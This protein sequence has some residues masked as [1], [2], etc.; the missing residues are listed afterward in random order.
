MNS[1]RL[2]RVTSIPRCYREYLCH[3]VRETEKERTSLNSQWF[4]GEELDQSVCNR[5]KALPERPTLSI[6]NALERSVKGRHVPR[7]C[8]KTA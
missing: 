6:D 4:F 7:C 8:R 5:F 3:V 2:V 1:E